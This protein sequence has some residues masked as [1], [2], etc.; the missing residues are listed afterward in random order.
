MIILNPA[1]TRAW[2]RAGKLKPLTSLP[3]ST[4]PGRMIGITLCFPNGA[5]RPS[6]TY[7]WREKGVIKVFLCSVY[8]PHELEDQKQ[9]YPELDQFIYDRPRNAEILMG[10]DISCNVLITSPRF[11]HTLRPHWID[12]RNLKGREL[13]Y[14]YKTNNL[15]VL[16][17]YFKHHNYVTY[18][19]FNESHIA[20]MLDNII[21]CNKFS[22]IIS[23]CKVTRSGVRSDHTAVVAKFRLT[24]IKFN[25]TRDEP[26]IIDWEKIRTDKEAKSDFN[27]RLTTLT[28]HGNTLPDPF[29]ESQ[30]TAFNTAILTAAT[31][32]AMRQ[33][34]KNQGWFHHSNSVLLPAI[35]HRD[36]L[37]HYLRSRDPFK[38]S[39]ALRAQLQ[40]SQVIVTDYVT[41]AK[42]AA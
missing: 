27:N 25:Y 17:T 2:A 41:L 34:K 35:H 28:A 33:K 22:K 16:L 18:R 24:S 29:A 1:L 7:H 13:L 8:H 38:D 21:C 39:I 40:E 9:F 36:H 15:K 23:D 10:A 5:N 12:N 6:D 20:H 11:S 37:L 19:S 32:T 14:L 30:Y 4:F 31:D 3:A 26:S 42:A